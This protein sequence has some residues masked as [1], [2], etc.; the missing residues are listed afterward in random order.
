MPKMSASEAFVETL[1][2]YGNDFY[3]VDP[4]LFSPAE[5]TFANLDTGRSFTYGKTNA[6][7]LRQSFGG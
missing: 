2:A 1:A 3:K 5:I 4:L 6:E 7:I